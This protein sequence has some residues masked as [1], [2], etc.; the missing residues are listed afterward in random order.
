MEDYWRDN[1]YKSVKS[2]ADLNYQKKAWLGKSKY[3]SSFNEVINVL[4]DDNCFEDFINHDYW[5]HENK[6][7]VE[8][9]VLN[10][11]INE[12]EEPNE[13]KKILKDP[14]WKAIT[15][16]ASK[17]ISLWDIEFLV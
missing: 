3:V 9:T 2:I 6:L 7:F 11:L 17:V 13:E 1:I 10:E 8:L 4:Y 16:Q 5:Q 12:Y 14:K 15:L